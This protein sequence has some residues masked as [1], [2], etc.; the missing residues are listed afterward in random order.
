MR[1][2]RSGF[3]FNTNR[4][5]LSIELNHAIALGVVHVIGKYGGAIVALRCAP[6]L[7]GEARSVKNVVTQHQAHRALANELLAQQKSLGQAVGLRLNGVLDTDTPL[8]AVPQKV[9]ISELVTGRSDD[10]NVTNT[11]LHQRGK[12]VVN[13]RLVVYGHQLLADR[14]CERV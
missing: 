6:E 8:A 11:R 3:F 7:T 10:Q 12:W 9:G 14:G 4:T 13:H 1:A 2:R 5:P